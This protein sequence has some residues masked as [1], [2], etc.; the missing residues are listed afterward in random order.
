MSRYSLH[1]I[2]A[3]RPGIVAS[4]TGVLADAG[5]NIE[6]SRMAIL[7]GQFAIMLIVEAPRALALS[8]L[9]EAFRP[10]QEALDL[11]VAVRPLVDEAEPVELGETVAV[12][13]HGADHPGIVSA[14]AKAIAD[15]GGNIVDL[16]THRLEDEQGAAYVLLLSVEMRGDCSEEGLRTTLTDVADRLGV[17]AVVHASSSE[18][19]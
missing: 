14:V 10:V 8:D 12:S 5:C 18:L 13:V 2:G 7:R 9:D 4:V 16:S 15:L 1:A 6:D 19:L 3:D 11:L 17:T